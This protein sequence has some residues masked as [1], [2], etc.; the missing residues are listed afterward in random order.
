MNKKFT[1]IFTIAMCILFALSSLT[2]AQKYEEKAR[3]KAEDRNAYVKSTHKY[4]PRLIN[5]EKAGLVLEDFESGTYP[6]TG[7]TEYHTGVDGLDQSTLQSWSPTHSVLFNDVTGV[8]TSWFIT[9]QV[10]ALDAGSQLSFYQRQYYYT[11]YEYHGIWISTVSGDPASG[12]F[13][14]IDSL[15]AG[16]NDTWEI[17]TV[18][19]SAYA[20][21][22]VY[23]AF[24]YSG[25]YA[26]EWYLDDVAIAPPAADDIGLTSVYTSSFPGVGASVTV[27]AIVT[28]F[29]ANAA[30]GFDVEL[31]VDD[32]HTDTYTYSGSLAAGAEDVVTFANP[33]VPA[34]SGDH[35]LTSWTE[36]TGDAD[37]SNDTSSTTVNVFYVESLNFKE[38]F[39][40]YDLDPSTIGWLGIADTYFGTFLPSTTDDGIWRAR[41]FGNDPALTNSARVNLYSTTSYDDDWLITPPIDMTSGGSNNILSFDAAMTPWTGTDSTGLNPEDTIY[42]V[43][44]TDGVTWDRSN[45]IASFNSTSVIL[46][47]GNHYEYDLSAWDSETGLHIGFYCIDHPGPGD[48]LFYID[49]VLVGV[50][51]VKINEVYY[52]TPSTDIHTFTELFGTPG[53]SL[54]GFSLVGVN[55]NGGATYATIDLTGYTIPQDGFFVIGQDTGVANVDLVNS[56]ADWQNGPDNVVLMN[57]AD[58]VDALGYGDF[59]SAVFVGEGN[60]AED[61]F[62]GVSLNRYPDGN[63]TDDNATD[64]HGAYPT[65]GINN[66]PPH[67]MIGGSSSVAFDSVMIGSDSTRSY[68]I[69]NNGSADLVVS[70]VVTSNAVFTV[71]WLDTV[72]APGANASLTVTFAPSDTVVYSDSLTIY[73]N[74]PLFGQRVVSLSG[75]GFG[76]P[77]VVINDLN[78]T[79]EDASDIPNWSHW[80]ET[81]FFTTEAW[82][83]TGGVGGSGAL[84][85]GDG[86]YDF[87]AKRPIV[88]TPGTYFSI[89]ADIRTSGW[90]SPGTFDLY[91]YVQGIADFDSVL[92]N[93]EGAFTTFTLRGMSTSDSGY[94][95][96]YGVNTL[97]HNDVWVDNVVFDDDAPAPPDPSVIFADDFEAYTAGV[98][99]TVQNS[100][101][102]TPWSG[103]PGVN[104][105]YVSTTYAHSG[106]NSI[107]VIT[108]DDLVKAMPNY[109]TG[110]YK[111]SFDLYVPTGTVAYFNTLQEFAP[112]AQWGM[113]V[114]FRDA[115]FGEIDGGGAL[116]ANFTYTYDTWLHNEVFVNLEKDTAEYYLDGVRVHGWKWTDGT[117]GTTVGPLQL[118]GNNFYGGGPTGTFNF[119]IDD[120][121]LKEISPAIFADNFDSYTAGTQLVVQNSI[122]WR[123]WSAGGAGTGEDPFVSDAYSNSGPNSVV[124]MPNND[125]VKTYGSKTSGVW[126]IAFN[127]Y[128]PNGQA[129]Y[130]N[131]MAGFDPNTNSWAMWVDFN[132]GGGAVLDGVPGSPVAFTYAYDTWQMVE[133][134]IDLD[135]DLAELHL[136]GA[137]IHQWQ[138]TDGG[139]TPLRLDATDFFGATANDEM[140]IDDYVFDTAASLTPNS[141]GDGTNALPTTF[142][143]A[144]NYPNP[145]NPTTTI[146]Y[147]LPKK[148]DVKIVIYNMLG[149]VVRT[150]VDKSVDAGYQEVVWDGLNDTGNR[151]ATGVYI[152][153]METD[154]FVK[155]HKMI[156]MK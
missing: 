150:I 90:G 99:L 140:Y 78:L 19:L 79:F 56:L 24:V 29:G 35:A 118:G 94:I 48:K 144:Q 51:S 139:T 46:P 130:F 60:P 15:G 87:I 92:I 104:D 7:W 93:S 108:D 40:T 76:T 115:G 95:R 84:L 116:A 117:F 152:Y 113:Q 137:V 30:T 57:G 135:Q 27:N 61:V 70:N 125:L 5:L 13:V 155:A 26:D 85:L 127:M 36:L 112:V 58:T 2:F 80:D 52:D 129:G 100:V 98:Q 126:S 44:S 114:Y 151:V 136:D 134:I 28:N 72:I 75:I 4:T 149:Q 43:V 142:D 9:P 10:I 67:P 49:N 55:G 23:V 65:P 153:R 81:N 105:P 39:E 102:W 147:Q 120:Y 32:G 62:S 54:D 122:D 18:D 141:I 119:Y 121:E 106:V 96:I 41:D 38:D 109:T 66:Y 3:A 86:G 74:D 110:A 33:W 101:D 34:A 107:N 82:D 59:S 124:I 25:D 16:T 45:I 22:D 89:S 91:L 6:P 14:E 50:P 97:G 71:D 17:K 73:N 103:T 143:L 131:T 156:M 42:V 1:E 31:S 154:K 63:D 111:I 138:W 148:A 20:G 132:V 69:Y 12:D 21:Q 77:I 8:D 11:Y 145:F 146:K 128:I 64:F 37:P 123:T 68:T 47:T 133:V 83:A 88:A 53:L